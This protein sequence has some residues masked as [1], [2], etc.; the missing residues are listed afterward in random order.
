MS[1]SYE[2]TKHY[3]IESQKVFNICKANPGH[4]KLQKTCKNGMMSN[5]AKLRELEQM[6]KS[7]PMKTWPYTGYNKGGRRSRRSTR[8]RT[9]RR[10]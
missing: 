10:R 1:K 2:N 6:I 3:S 9:V 4:N 5:A 7:K 8:R